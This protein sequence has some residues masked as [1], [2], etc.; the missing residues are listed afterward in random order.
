MRHLFRLITFL[1]FLLF[2]VSCGQ[3]EDLY[4]P[5]I[6][7]I[8]PM[9]GF[10]VDLPDT[11]DVQVSISDYR[12]VR[13]AV[14]TLVNENL[15]PVVQAKY[16][17]PNSMNF[18]IKASIPLDDN[19]LT[20]GA[21][22]LLITVSDNTDQKNKYLPVIIH[23]IPRVL[24]AYMV[25]TAQF[26]SETTIIKLN[27]DFETDT[28]FVFSHRYWLSAVQSKWGQFFFV[29]AEPSNL[30]AFNPDSFETEWEMTAPFPEPLITAL[31]PD[32]QLVFSTANGDAG[33]LS[34]EGE[35]SLRTI[36][37]DNRTIQCL[38]ADDK[39]IY[40]A[41][42]SLNGN[43]HE[44][45]VFSRLNADIWVQQL[46]AGEIR[47]LVPLGQ[48]LLVFLQLPEGVKIMEFN[49]QNFVLTQLSL[50][51]GEN[52][53]S[54]LKISDKQI[55]ILTDEKVISYNPTSFL[56]SNFINQPYKFCR[57]DPLTDLVFLAKGN[58][59]YGFNRTTG[60]LIKEKAFPEEVLDFQILYNK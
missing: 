42:V 48:H 10:I 1:G 49:P 15:V 28:Q 47:S 33:I 16:Y 54:T 32:E 38:A 43:I 26:D 13:T 37:F 3:E 56:F 6:T 8:K 19:S 46:I 9:A 44:L 5:E 39:Y 27:P 41:H 25:M 45:T 21:Y 58:M 2:L 35:I 22:S 59:I 14:L 34:D 31:F 36:A 17:Y 29:T 7:F 12:I 52:V 55:L 57:Y 40:A 11:I 23:E 20:S 53:I 18:N 51:P 30:V 4:A 50:L 24:K 60:A